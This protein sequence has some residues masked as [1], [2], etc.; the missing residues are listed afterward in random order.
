MRQI[1][2]QKLKMKKMMKEIL[3]MKTIQTLFSKLLLQ[4]QSHKEL[5]FQRKIFA[6]YQF[7]DTMQIIE[8]PI[9]KQNLLNIT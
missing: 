4:V 8:K 5:R 7:A 3:P 1:K 9:I 2:I 6:L